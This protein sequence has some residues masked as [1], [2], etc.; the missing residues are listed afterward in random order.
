MYEPGGVLLQVVHVLTSF[1]VRPARSTITQAQQVA[2]L[3]LGLV[4]GNLGRMR[5]CKVRLLF[6]MCLRAGLY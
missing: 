5:D 6:V 4:R 2:F 3:G 1:A